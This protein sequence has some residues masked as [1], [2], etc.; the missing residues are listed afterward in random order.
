MLFQIQKIPVS[1]TIKFAHTT[2]RTGK[3]TFRV[4]LEGCVMTT[5]DVS[6]V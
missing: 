1:G 6:T 4:A 2:R 3:A 5:H